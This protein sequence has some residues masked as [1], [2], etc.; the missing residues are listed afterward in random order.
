MLGYSI[1]LR[2]ETKVARLSVGWDHVRVKYL[3]TAH[4]F[5]Y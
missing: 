4:N 3:T 2:E 5:E 1:I